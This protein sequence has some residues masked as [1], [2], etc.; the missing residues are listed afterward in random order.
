[1]ILVSACLLGHHTKYDGGSNPTP[2]IMRYA[3]R[4]QFIAFCPEQMGGLAIPHPASEII[5]GSGEQVLAGNRK[6]Q[7]VTGEDVTDFFRTGAARAATLIANRQIT[8]AILKQRSP[9]C[10]TTQ[11]YDGTFSGGKRPG[12]GVTAAKLRQLNIPLYS[13]EDLTDEI[14]GQLLARDAQLRK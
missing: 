8:A 12:M 1:M 3:S 13:E 14:L 6:V 9:S 4:N 5:A 2:L 10:G 7:A 11:I